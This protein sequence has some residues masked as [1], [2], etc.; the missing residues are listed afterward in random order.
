M[1]LTTVNVDKEIQNE[2]TIQVAIEMPFDIRSITCPTHKVR[3]KQTVTK[4]TV[5]L[6]ANQALNDGFQLWI[7]LAQIHVPRMW[8]ERYPG[9]HSEACM[10]TF[11]PEFDA[12]SRPDFE[13]VFLLD[14]SNSMDGPA[15]VDA[16]KL[17]L[18]LL[19]HLP[20]KVT[21]NIVVFGTVFH[22]LFPTSQPKTKLNEVAAQRF[23]QETEPPW[24]THPCPPPPTLLPVEVV[25]PEMCSLSPTHI[26]THPPG[27]RD[28][29]PQSASFLRC[30]VQATANRHL[31][32]RLAQAGAGAYETFDAATKYKWEERVTR[33]LSK[34]GQPSLSS[35]SV[36]WQQFDT[37]A[38]P[39]QAPSHVTS[40]FS[41]SRQVI[42]GLVSNCTQ[43]ELKAVIDNQ[44]IST[45]VST[46]ELN[47]TTGKILHQLTARAAIRDWEEGVLADS[48]TEHEVTKKNRKN[49]ILQLSTKYSIVTQFTSFVAVEK[50][51]EGETFRGPCGPSIAELVQRESVDTL[52]YVAWDDD[53]KPPI[54]QDGGQRPVVIE[55][56]Y[57]AD[58]QM[59]K[60][61]G[62]WS[63]VP[64]NTEVDK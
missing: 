18:L 35:V 61:S 3:M 54:T 38:A 36:S 13:V 37:D 17:L 48:R 7:H 1:E 9:T 8:V 26:T 42:Y 63:K 16:K 4:A 14:L 25:C 12:V 58:G 47:I 44:E 30:R 45:M 10:L 52:K 19:H 33:Q 46:T 27:R 29:A 2:V 62:Q 20:P 22:E 43:A 15:L 11:Y 51:E 53:V 5:E 24:E 31:L 64:M 32:R 41:G 6:A 21:F 40:L 56:W 28:H 60:V 49:L 34:A 39:L 55:L 50:R 57:E 59:P 23:I